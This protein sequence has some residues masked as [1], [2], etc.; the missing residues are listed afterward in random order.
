MAGYFRSDLVDYL[1]YGFP[2]GVDP[3]GH[4]EPTLKN[5]SSSYMFFSHMDKFC[6]KEISKGE[7]SL[8]PPLENLSTR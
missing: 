8:M 6:L 2:I 4:T 3:D 5:H 7:L 1:E